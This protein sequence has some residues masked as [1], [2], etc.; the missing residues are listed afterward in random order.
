MVDD[1]IFLPLPPAS[2]RRKRD[3][4]RPMTEAE[5]VR[6]IASYNAWVT[7]WN[8]HEGSRDLPLSPPWPEADLV[9]FLSSL[10]VLAFAPKDGPYRLGMMR[11]RRW[12]HYEPGWS[13]C[14][15][16]ADAERVVWAG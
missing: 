9:V 3:G 8:K 15:Q 11:L 10:A 16:T 1:D 12:K 2:F 5:A 14:R 13:I 6:W 4:F 7:I